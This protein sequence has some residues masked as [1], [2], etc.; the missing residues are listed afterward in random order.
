MRRN[1]PS[2]SVISDRNR[3]SRDNKVGDN[4]LP[5]KLQDP[6][7]VSCFYVETLA[8]GCQEGPTIWADEETTKQTD[9][10][11]VLT[12]NSTYKIICN[13]KNQQKNPRVSNRHV[14]TY[15]Y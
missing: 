4:A 8:D 7:T 3:L 5:S 14:L 10:E 6:P 1:H 11:A 15:F 9:E 2:V 12:Y 13:H